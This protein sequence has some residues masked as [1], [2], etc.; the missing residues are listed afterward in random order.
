MS[1][2]PKPSELPEGEPKP[3]TKPPETLA[4]MVKAVL[5]L[6][7]GALEAFKLATRHTTYQLLIIVAGGCAV[8][9]LA[10]FAA[11]RG[12]WGVDEKLALPVLAFLGGMLA[13]RKS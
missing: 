3:A 10:Y 6:L 8:L 1:A 9:G 5:P 13:G 12:E 2:E 11:M 4:D 7:P